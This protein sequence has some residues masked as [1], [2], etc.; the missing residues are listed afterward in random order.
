MKLR[1]KHRS[2]GAGMVAVGVIAA[3]LVA[4]SATSAAAVEPSATAVFSSTP[5]LSGIDKARPGDA[6]KDPAMVATTVDGVQCW[7]MKNDPYV[8]YLYVDVA[9]SAIPAGATR[10]LVTVDYYDVGAAG[11]DI[12]YDAKSNPWTGSRNQ[13]LTDTHTW[14]STTFELTGINF[15]NR[16]NGHDFR[17]NVKAAQGSMPP[18]CFSKVEVTFTDKP[19]AA[20]DSLAIMNDSLIF[21]EGEASVQVSTPADEVTWRVGDENDVELRTGTAAIS[22]GDGEIDLSDLPFGYYTLDVTA[23]LD[24]PVTRTTSFAVLD[25]P[26]P[27]WNDDGAFFGTQLHRS[28]QPTEHTDA[29]IDAMELA[30]YGISRN[31]TT[32]GEVEKEKGVY[33]FTGEGPRVVTELANRG[34]D[35]MW[36]AGLDNALY[37]N[38]RT[39]A[40]TEAIAA[41]AAYVG[42]TAEHFSTAG[43]SHDIGI[44]NEYNSTGF[45]DGTCGLTAACYLQVLQPSYV[46]AHAADPQANV[47]GPITA[48][49]Q[50][51]WAQDFIAQG[52]LASLDTYATNYYGYAQNGPGTPPEATTELAAL[53]QL[54]AMIDANDGGRDIPLRVTENGWP[55][56]DAGST[57]AQQ[58][59]YAIRGPLL[60]Q[61]AGA[62]EY[63]W[64]DLYDDGFDSAER[65]NRFGL[66]NRAD[67]TACWNWICPTANYEYGA[68]HGISPKP[69][70]VT[71]AV[72]I[73][74]TVGKELTEREALGSDSLY[75]LMYAGDTAQDATRVLWSTGTDSVTVTST[76]GFTLTDKFGASQQVAK[77]TVTLQLNGSPVFVGGNVTV[78]AAG[79]AFALEVPQTTVQGR[80]VP[81]TL[82]IADASHIR[83]GK[84][85]V[86]ADGVTKTVKVDKGVAALTLPAVSRLGEREVTVTV[87]DKKGRLVSEVHATT[88]VVDPYGMSVQPV[89]TKTDAGFDYAMAITVTN[90]AADVDVTVDSIDWKVGAAS[91]T[92]TDP[93]T[94]PASGSQTVSI[95][96]VDPKLFQTQSYAVTAHAGEVARSGKG[97]LSFSPIEKEGATTLDEI[98]LNT[99]GKWNAIR[100]GTRTGP[101][102]LGGSVRYTATV[103]A[104]VLH[105]T[106]TDDVHLADRTDPALSWQADSVQFN[107]YDTLPASLGGER[108]EI[109]AALSAAGPVVYT[110]APP[111]GSA[112]GL[113]PGATA[114]IVR[115]DAA[116]TTTYQ[117]SVPW[118]SL[119]YDGPPAGVWGLSFLVNDADGDVAGGD[120][121]A[122]YIEWGSGVG[123]APKNPAL[124]K[125]VQIVGLD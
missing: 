79:A 22:G 117:V 113:T 14:K 105:A 100:S 85:T 16:E 123:G 38:G 45:N 43:V 26:P 94:V 98:D 15:A 82:T 39:P 23:A 25:D 93:V 64:Y 110:F 80:D 96:V 66:I 91:G 104:L 56:H 106:I 84:V 72:A 108:V 65:E 118:S 13:Q 17:L 103:D 57:Q 120:S 112:P 49:V 58:A 74:Q 44:L 71:Q 124:F 12:H 114:D 60:A 30:G 61:L 18:V 77:G 41:F 81:V 46:A 125:T 115:D 27:G 76:K 111:A 101:A 70:F 10:A 83:G 8:R 33:G 19:I 7:E 50:L 55:T 51:A 34:V 29:L 40:S 3:G 92:T 21:K 48:G 67:D 42:A 97:S 5:Q 89:I 35:V 31:E 9:Q 73:R 121:R 68:V 28:W 54:A 63:L 47:I 52:G 6:G 59:D 87:T 24:E 36:N 1:Q 107:T 11:F 116:G 99:I 4:G 62:D 88:K 95:P 86:E 119:G 2:L 32:W 37:D 90:N 102:D 109:A 78:A 20:I 75:S 53:A 69:G 122:G